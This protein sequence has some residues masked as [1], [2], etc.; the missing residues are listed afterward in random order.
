MLRLRPHRTSLCATFEPTATCSSASARRV[1]SMPLEDTELCEIHR[2][3]T[4]YLTCGFCT[5]KY[6]EIENI[7]TWNCIHKADGFGGEI[8]VKGD[9]RPLETIF[10]PSTTSYYTHVREWSEFCDFSTNLGPVI[11]K[12]T[13]FEHVANYIPPTKIETLSPSA[14]YAVYE[15]TGN[16]ENHDMLRMVNRFDVETQKALLRGFDIH[17]KKEFKRTKRSLFDYTTG[18]SFFVDVYSI[19]SPHI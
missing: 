4:E 10:D 5:K 3:N 14:R 15:K 1:V 11:R 9:H 7:G 19:T 17:P 6:L 18:A 12:R 8:F 2:W 13:F 16:K